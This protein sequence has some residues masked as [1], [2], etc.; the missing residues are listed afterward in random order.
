MLGRSGASATATSGWVIRVNKPTAPGFPC[1]YTKLLSG[2]APWAGERDHFNL[3]FFV[4]VLFRFPC[5]VP[6][7]EEEEAHGCPPLLFP[8][9][10]KTGLGAA[11]KSN[12]LY[13]IGDGTVFTVKLFPDGTASIVSQLA[14]AGF[15]GA[16]DITSAPGNLVYAVSGAG[17]NAYQVFVD[18]SFYPTSV[19]AAIATT[20]SVSWSFVLFF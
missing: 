8:L 9:L 7:E 1:S 17:K 11:P 4:F 20:G 18:G 12:L 5:V 14:F 16:G 6:Q 13:G 3:F 15:T 10:K 2:I 19:S